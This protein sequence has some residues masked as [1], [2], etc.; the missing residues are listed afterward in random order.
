MRII[1]LRNK[2]KSICVK[3]EENNS[4]NEEMLYEMLNKRNHNKQ[5]N[6]LETVQR[7]ITDIEEDGDAALL[8]YTLDFDKVAL[9][10]ETMKVSEKEI[11]AAYD[12]ITP[13]LLSIIKKAADNI[14]GFHAK[15]KPQT[16]LDTDREG[17]IR[18]T[19]YNVCY[20]KLLR[21]F[22]ASNLCRY[23]IHQY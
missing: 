4:P 15:Q 8:K 17:I 22:Y 9:T 5:T 19:S 21:S 10:S 20:T 23:C 1:D 18:I 7:V 2:Y 3:N 11:K 12:E 14:R 16:W 6:V 13:E